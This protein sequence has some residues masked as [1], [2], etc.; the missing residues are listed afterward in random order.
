M[1]ALKGIAEP[2]DYYTQREREREPEA[3]RLDRYLEE[4]GREEVEEVVEE[5]EEQ[6][7]RER[8]LA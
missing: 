1:D 6:E 3:F 7:G 8:R 4:E 2:G 5:E